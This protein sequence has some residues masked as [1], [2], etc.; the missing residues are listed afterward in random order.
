MNTKITKNI[1]SKTSELKIKVSLDKQDWKNEQKKAYNKLSK[2]VKVPGF[3]PGKAPEQDLKKY[4]STPK[5][6]EEAI[7]KLLNEL[8][9]DAAS[10]ITKDDLILDSP[11][12]SVDKITEDELEI[13]Y[14]Y[15]TFVETKLKDYKNLKIKYEEI[16]E[17][18]IKEA[19][20]KELDS[21]LQKGSVLIPKSG[22]DAKVEKHN[23]INFD[24]KGYLGDKPFEGGE[25]KNYELEIGSGLFIP[26]FEEKLIGKTLGWEGDIEVSFPKDYF[27]DD[28]KGKKTRFEI[29]INEIKERDL[30]KLDDSYVKSLGIKDVKNKSDLDAY[31]DKVS[32][33]D[34]EEKERT[35]FM[36]DFIDKL[37]FD[38]DIIIPNT[39]IQKEQQKLLKNFEQQLKSQKLS[40]KDYFEITK[41]NDE[42]LNNELKSEAEKSIKKSFIYWQLFKDLKIQPTEEDYNRQYSRISRLYNIDLETIKSMVKKENIEDKIKEELLT[43]KLIELNNPG[44]K[45]KKEVVEKSVKKDL[46][47]SSKNKAKNTK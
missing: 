20:K 24:F 18:R 15:P 42:K 26:G 33:M 34:L 45:I 7:S 8:I 14:I 23:V 22:K 2:K 12:Y 4:V 43:D 17:K 6:W 38:N 46:S 37:I 47:K 29:K 9:K 39:I 10:K 11:T 27:N 1:D 25:A 30:P 13:T 21:M 3:R 32:K 28:L 40:K 36:N 35:K 31:L 16:T 44:I 19:S 41:Y 5:I